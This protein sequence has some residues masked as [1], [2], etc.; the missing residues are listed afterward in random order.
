ML[1]HP[2]HNFDR[3][4]HVAM[5][6]LKL[7]GRST[8]A[9]VSSGEWSAGP[10]NQGE[11]ATGPDP[12]TLFACILAVLFLGIDHPGV[13]NAQLVTERAILASRYG[14]QG[15]AEQNS[16]DIG[17]ALFIDDDFSALRDTF[18]SSSK[19]RTALLQQVSSLVLATEMQYPGFDTLGIDAGTEA[20]GNPCP[21]EVT[22]KR[23]IQASNVAHTMQHWHIYRKW[24]ERLFAESFQAYTRGRS[25]SHPAKFWYESE[26]HLFDTYVLPLAAKLKESNYFGTSGEECFDYATKNRN[27]WELHGREIVEEMARRAET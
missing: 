17:W 8:L 5:A 16:I 12:Q 24:S 10:E 18:C 3:A 13:P 11:V 2:F 21:E 26:L 14:N 27:E 7:L 23:L 22:L 4:T 25:A 20:E 6:L 1:D 15:I 9:Q 19:E